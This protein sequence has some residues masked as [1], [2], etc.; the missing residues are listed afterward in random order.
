MKQSNPAF[1]I[2]GVLGLLFSL[3]IIL[4]I[5]VDSYEMVKKLSYGWLAVVVV[6][7]S[8]FGSFFFMLNRK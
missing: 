8:L 3:I 4:F 7:L 2:L 1:K 6:I 5:D